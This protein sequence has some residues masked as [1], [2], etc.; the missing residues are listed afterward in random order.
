MRKI[1]LFFVGIVFTANAYAGIN[2]D[3]RTVIGWIGTRPEYVPETVENK[4]NTPPYNNYVSVYNPNIGAYGTGEFISPKHILT[5]S[6]VAENC[7]IENN[8]CGIRMSNGKEV[9]AVTVFSGAINI[10]EMIGEEPNGSNDWAILEIDSP[11]FYSDHWFEYN[12]ITSDHDNLWRAG[13]GGLRV[14]SDRDVLNI[15]AAYNEYLESIGEQMSTRYFIPWAQMANNRDHY[16]VFLNAYQKITGKDFMADCLY[17]NDTL[18]AIYGCDLQGNK[19][20]CYSWSGDS[21]SSIQDANNKIVG[22]L[23][24]NHSAMVF[25]PGVHTNFVVRIE[26]FI[27]SITKPEIEQA[28]KDKRAIR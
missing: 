28:K 12:D 24:G 5:N 26:K 1:A 16:Q 4:W 23:Y 21:G 19:T 25:Y 7:G 11:D 3:R 17:D 8:P 6:H 13:F 22:L 10:S 2:G 18:K 14:L 27:N 15:R 20:S 9:S